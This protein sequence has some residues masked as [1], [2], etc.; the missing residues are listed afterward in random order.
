M[1][2]LADI[3]TR[4][5]QA[6]RRN[7]TGIEDLTKLLR[8]G[9]RPQNRLAI[10]ARHYAASLSTAL[11]DKFPGCV[12][13]LGAP[14]VESAARA[15][16]RAFAPAHPCI[17]EYGATF[18]EFLAAHGRAAELPY[19]EAFARLEWLAGKASIAVAA[20]ALD[21]RAIAHVGTEALLDSTLDLQ[22]G[23]H[24]LRA[25]WPVDALLRA[26]L[27]ESAPERFAMEPV[28][29]CIEIRGARGDLALQRLEAAAFAFRSRLLAG[30]T[31]AAAAEAALDVDAAFDPAAALHALEAASLLVRITP[32]DWRSH[33]C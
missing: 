21:W 26:Y 3:Q 13:L 4:I 6:V 18:P 23:T 32:P 30:S 10:H 33:P 25:E 5:A 19:V 20:P 16:A 15:H 31:I 17:A 28:D 7:D 9:V 22:P 24:Y 12:W 29:V 27:S 1:P 11:L 14:L 2:T 8:G